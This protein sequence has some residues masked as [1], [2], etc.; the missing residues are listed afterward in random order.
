[1]KSF[2]LAI[3]IAV[4]IFGLCRVSA[5]QNVYGSTTINIDPSSGMVTATCETNFDG[6]LDGNYQAQVV[7][8]VTDQNGTVVAHADNADMDG[9]GS[10]EVMLTFS[11]TPGYTYTATSIHHAIA[12][13]VEQVYL[14]TVYED[15]FNLSN[16]YQSEASENYPNYNDWFGPG[17][18]QQ[19][20]TVSLRLGETFASKIRYYTPTELSQIITGA[21]TLFSPHCDSVFASVIGSS[22]NNVNFFESLR[23]TSF[24]Q[25]PPGAANI[26]SAG[27]SGA[28]ADT[29][30]LQPDRPIELFPNF[31]PTKA[32]PPY[33]NFQQYVLIH[34]GVHRYTGW[35]D[36][37]SQGS[38]DF[39][40]QFYSSGY[41]NTTGNSDDFTQWIIAG[42]PP[43]P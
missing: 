33:P 42:C 27:I 19:A 39:E 17:P 43:A 36:F 40:T 32:G 34:E 2:R 29:L 15:P 8:T 4:V 9:V 24:I 23:A 1:M 25:Y 41:R 38:L 12:V 37:P 20:K 3:V 21:Q 22:Y 7:C 31:Y 6:A 14:K 18:E 30:V 35:Y 10:T 11:G 26:P 13:L 16:A 5:A 28:D